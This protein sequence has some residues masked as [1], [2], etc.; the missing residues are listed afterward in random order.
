MQEI[1]KL[2]K[3]IDLKTQIFSDDETQKLSALRD[4]KKK[5]TRYLRNK[6]PENRMALA[7]SAAAAYFPATEEIDMLDKAKNIGLGV[8]L[9]LL[10]VVLLAPTFGIGTAYAWK[11]A[12]SFFKEA[13]GT[14]ANLQEI[15]KKDCLN[16]S[17][18]HNVRQ[19]NAFSNESGLSRE[20]REGLTL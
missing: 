8:L 17:P 4:F 3:S 18:K 1:D 9:V 10:G 15:G 11:G 5:T 20:E 13:E 12:Y 14:Q 6:T 19:S 2:I 7:N 16:V